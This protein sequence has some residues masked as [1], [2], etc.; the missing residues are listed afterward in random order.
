MDSTFKYPVWNTGVT[1]FSSLF[2]Y[3]NTTYIYSQHYTH[4]LTQ[5]PHSQE[6]RYVEERSQDG[7]PRELVTHIYSAM[8][9]FSLVWLSRLSLSSS[10]TQIWSLSFRPS[11][12]YWHN[13]L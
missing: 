6:V 10:L 7:A 11:Y 3:N 13:L 8:Q 2:P 1:A 5:S 9:W 12:F 4:T